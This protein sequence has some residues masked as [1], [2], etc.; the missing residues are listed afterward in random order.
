MNK[1]TRVRSEEPEHHANDQRTGRQ[2]HTEEV[3][4][5]THVHK[6]NRPA[7]QRQWGS[8]MNQLTKRTAYLHSFLSPQ[9]CGEK[10]QHHHRRCCCVISVLAPPTRSRSTNG[11]SCVCPKIAFCPFVRGYPF[12][13]PQHRDADT[14]HRRKRKKKDDDCNE[15]KTTRT[16]HHPFVLDNDKD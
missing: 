15:P 9:R 16:N 6:T 8:C 3:L 13:S 12:C 14:Q 10:V 1:R 5:H 2:I 7:Q 4:A 11:L